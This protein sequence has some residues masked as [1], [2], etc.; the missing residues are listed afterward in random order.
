MEPITTAAIATLVTHLAA[1]GFEK[2]FDTSIEEFTKDSIHWLKGIFF[3][4]NKPKEVLEKLQEKPDSSARQ[5][6]AKAAIAAAIE[7]N[8]E[9]VKYLNEIDKVIKVKYGDT[10][11]IKSKNVNTGTINAGSNAIIGDQ[12]TL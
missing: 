3:K 5:E 6:A 1:K 2:A 12:N 10:I 7:N 8:P 9:D 4:D 11:I